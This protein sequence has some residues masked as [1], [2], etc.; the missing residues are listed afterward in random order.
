MKLKTYEIFHAISWFGAYLGLTAI[1]VSLFE[2]L[3]LPFSVSIAMT[4]VLSLTIRPL[5]SP[6]ERTVKL[7]KTK[8]AMIGFGAILTGVYWNTMD[9]GSMS[10]AVASSIIGLIIVLASSYDR[11]WDIYRE[12]NRGKRNLYL[13][14]IAEQSESKEDNLEEQIGDVQVRGV[15]YLAPYVAVIY[16]SLVGMYLALKYI[17]HIMS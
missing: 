6:L 14:H 16:L 5:T 13:E 11:L 10:D 8:G 3:F 2:E 17:K 12:H 4:A 9:A 7:Y 1:L 15:R